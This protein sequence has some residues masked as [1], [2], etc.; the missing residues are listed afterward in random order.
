MPAIITRG[1][2]SA[3]GFGYGAAA[4]G[5][6]DGT[7]GIFALGSLTTTRN[8]YTYSTCSSTAC[9]VAASS[10]T[11]YFGSATGN[12]TRGIFAI[13]DTCFSATVTREKYTY[14][15]CSST[16]CG[17]GAACSTAGSGSAASWAVCV[18]V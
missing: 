11:S 7:K 17:V 15:N 10:I 5:G 3:Q 12:S 16:A 1:A 4:L 14:S 9:G 2:M 13:G 6:G 18:N 8:K